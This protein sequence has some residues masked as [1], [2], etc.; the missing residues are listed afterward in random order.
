LAAENTPPSIFCHP[1]HLEE[2][3]EKLIVDRSF[4]EELGRKAQ[5]F[6]MTNWQATKVAERY[7]MLIEGTIPKEWL[8]DPKNIEYLHGCGLSEKKAKTIIA[9]FLKTGGEKSLCLSDKPKLE[10]MFVKFAGEP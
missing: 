10:K 9:A 1:D 8:Y 4:R 5:E 3:M 6:V 7:I 2:A